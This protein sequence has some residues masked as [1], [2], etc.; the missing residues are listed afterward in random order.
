M[1][2]TTAGVPLTAPGD[3]VREN[4]PAPASPGRPAAAPRE[5]PPA[6][7]RVLILSADMGEGHNAAARAI[8]EV[9][10]EL[11]PSCTVERLDTVELRGRRFASWA[12]WVYSFQL[13]HAPW[14]YQGFYDAL[15]R[16]PLFADPLK[17]A[18]SWFFGRRLEPQLAGRDVDL[19]ISTYP[20]GSGAL[21][22]MRSRRGYAVP[23]ATFVPA[24]HVHPYWAYTGIDLH[25]VMYEGAIRDARTPG[26][27][28]RMHVGSPM[29][30]SSFADADRHDARRQLGLVEDAFVV[31]VTGGA[32]GLGAQEEAVQALVELPQRVQ[33]VTVCGKNQQL[34]EALASMG[35]PQERLCVL[36]YVDNMASLMAASDA[37]VTNGAG[38]TVLEALRTARPVIAFQPLAGHGRAA[39]AVMVGLDLALL[40]EDVG[41]LAA[42]VAEL[43]TSP[44]LMRRLEQAGREFNLGKD[45]RADLRQVAALLDAPPPPGRSGSSPGPVPAG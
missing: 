10:G 34:R 22:W 24:F 16:W 43:A 3:A 27:E 2:G 17:R 33:V 32:W 40:C 36:G 13:H 12:R 8:T 21:D 1:T 28:G 20:L 14:L 31:L 41:S 18:T 6:P 26:L 35:A 23:T 29:V 5:G 30:H 9:I 37:V 39:S 45:L 42:T 11:W 4:E 19:V 7:R 44:A 25:F 38:V 15:C